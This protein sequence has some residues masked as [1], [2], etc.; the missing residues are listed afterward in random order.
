MMKMKAAML[1]VCFLV[2]VV[3]L[4]E[5]SP[6]PEYLIIREVHNL[7]LIISTHYGII[8]NIIILS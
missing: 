6:V 5:C 1:A 4:A 7:P 8:Y 2:S 3:V